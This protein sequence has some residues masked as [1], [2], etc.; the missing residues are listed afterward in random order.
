MYNTM[1]MSIMVMITS[2][3]NPVHAFDGGDGLALVFGMI[4]GENLKHAKT[5]TYYIKG[6]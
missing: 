4:I 6:T 2:L 5:L 3:V 1:Y